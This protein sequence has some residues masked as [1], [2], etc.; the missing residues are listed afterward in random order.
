M[1]SNTTGSFN[2]A[3][4]A[5][6]G[7]S[8]TTGSN[9]IDIGNE[10]RA[11]EANTI[12]IGRGGTHANNFIAGISGVIV[13]G[14]VGVI[15]D[16]NGKLGTVV[17]SERFKHEIKSMDKASEAILALKPVTFRY[18]KELD[19]AG[20]PQFG[21][22]AEQVEKVN[23]ALV[24][25]DAEGKVFTVRY[26]AV[27][28]MLLNEFLKEHREVQEQKATIAKQQKQI[29]ALTAGLQKV[30]DQLELSKPAPQVVNNP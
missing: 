2:I 15:I 17:S 23:P 16:N 7:D 27:N 11:G 30:S 6:A 18:K 8:L 28:A 24:A 5:N 21:L 26:E 20:I 25:R 1:R 9:N 22:V 13:A 14:G 12:R 4:G 3:L 10:G 19:P 29:E